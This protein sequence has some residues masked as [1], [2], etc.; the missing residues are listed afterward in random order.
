[1]ETQI[2]GRHAGLAGA[3]A[4]AAGRYW[5]DVFPRIEREVRYWRRRAEQIP[6]PALRRLALAN[7][8]AERGNLDGAAAFAT[9]T[10][11]AHRDTVVR[12]QVAFQIIYD[13]LDSLAEQPSDD[14][15]RNGRQLHRALLIALDPTAT[16]LDYYA[17]HARRCDAGYLEDL[18][19]ACRTAFG[20]LPSGSSVAASALR[21]T[22][23]MVAYQ[24]LVHDDRRGSCAALARWAARQTPAPLGL[25]WWEAA[26][27]GASSLIVFALIAAAAEPALG[28]RETAAVESAYFPWIGALHVLLDSLVDRS[29]DRDAGRPGLVEH[30]R[31][32]G[33]AAVRLTLLASHASAAARTLEHRHQHTV[34]LA[35][36]A[37]H[38]LSSSAATLP[39]ALP[40][41]RGVLGSL[42]ALSRPTT[43]IFSV[44]RGTTRTASIPV[45]SLPSG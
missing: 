39:D 9:F 32:P 19:D 33:E 1:M 17:H 14:P 36:M 20:A 13:Y 21:A 16:H 34:L 8:R 38:Y 2:V 40:A 35:G 37:G 7:L 5:L 42:G 25:R 44:R 12:A 45:A 4:G 29:Q 26:A 10:P 41:T 23:R 28:T 31:S 3:F 15:I 30:Y 6:D 27:A 18:V 11:R 24:S 22:A 43:M